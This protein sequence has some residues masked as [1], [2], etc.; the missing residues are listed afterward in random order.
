MTDGTEHHVIQPTLD[1]DEAML[2]LTLINFAVL[3]LTIGDDEFKHNMRT[4]LG[5]VQ[6]IQNLQEM[7]PSRVDTLIRRHIALMEKAFPGIEVNI[8]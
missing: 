8:L 1:L 6:A 5:R 3:E 4:V 7:G 2:I